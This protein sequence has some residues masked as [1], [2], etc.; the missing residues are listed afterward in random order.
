MRQQRLDDDTFPAL[1]TAA[2]KLSHQRVGVA[3]YHQPG[4]AIGFAMHQ[5]H[6][7]TLNVKQRTGL[8]RSGNARA[9]KSRVN[10]LGFV[11][12]PDAG[13]YLGAGTDGG[14]SQKTPV[15]AL[16]LDSF[17][18]VAAALGDGAVKHPRVA[19]LQR[20][21]LAFSKPN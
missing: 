2:G 8:E 15:M 21:L 11:K 6:A 18:G 10:A 20:A 1:D 16:N 3:V 17:T 7:V 12:A 4:Q 13:A 9:E 14:P 5:A 19:A